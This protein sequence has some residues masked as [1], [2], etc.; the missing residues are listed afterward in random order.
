MTV[1]EKIWQL[2][3]E[4]LCLQFAAL[5]KPTAGELARK[6]YIEEQ[7]AVIERACPLSWERAKQR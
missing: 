1:V 4:L 2:S 3:D 6:K 7:L 5:A